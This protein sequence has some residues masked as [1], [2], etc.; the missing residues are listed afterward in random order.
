MRKIGLAALTCLELAPPDLVAVAAE[1]GYDFVGLRLI[2]AAAGQILPPFELRELERRLADTG[3]K[4]L[5]VEVFRVSPEG[6]VKDYEPMLA[7]AARLGATDILVHGADPDQARLVDNFGR[8]CDL[9]AR[10]G[11]NAN[12]EPMP[13]VDV[14]TVVNAKRVI[15]SSGRKN[16][17][18]LPDPI[19]FYR[20]D[21]SLEDLKDVPHRYLQFCDAR[22]E[23]PTEMQEMIRQARGDRLFP[24]EGGLDL[25]EFLAALPAGL[26][27]SLEIP[28]AGGFAPLE[29]A[30]RALQATRKLLGT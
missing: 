1:C 28:H 10:Y 19:H 14:S 2:P 5:D 20:A 15:R 7:M 16:A 11:L 6:N 30:R 27:M 12:L 22:R 21:N 4:V 8:L 18:H 9:C 13:W 25:R 24:G 26:P 29:R 23:R 3:M 17:A